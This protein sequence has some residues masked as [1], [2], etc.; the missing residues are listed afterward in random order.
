MKNNNQNHTR[1]EKELAYLYDLYVVPQWR[2][3]FDRIVDEELEL[4]EEGKF[5][6]AGCGTGSYA[7]D[8][9]IRG[10]AK[11]EVIGVDTDPERLALARSK[12]E[13]KK[14]D[15]ITFQQGSL[16]ALEF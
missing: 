4:P 2:E 9:A 7:I 11:V 10:G 14:L 3:A 12:A 16:L 8:L 13:I 15:R 1:D 6:D 5:L